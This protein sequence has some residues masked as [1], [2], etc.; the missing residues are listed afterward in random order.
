MSGFAIGYGGVW[1]CNS[2]RLE[3]IP[4]RDGDDVPDGP[5]EPILDGFSVDAK[6]IFL[7]G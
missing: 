7:M 5:S 1:I 6:H 2:P 3:F 4:D